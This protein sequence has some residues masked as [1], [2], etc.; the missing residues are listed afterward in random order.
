M[1]TSKYMLAS[2]RD[3]LWGL[4]VS[5]IG[6]E[7]IG[8]NEDY[9]TSGH[10]SGYYF[11]L[12]KGRVLDEYQMLYVV[13]GRGRFSSTH[14]HNVPLAAGDAFL[15]FPGEWHCYHP[16]FSEGWKC[17]WIGF[18]GKN[19]DDRVRSGFLS[20]Q[21]P[22]Y[23]LGYSSEIEHLYKTAFIT[24]KEEKAYSQQMLAGIVNHMIGLMYS[25]ER[26]LDLGNR[27]GHSDM[28]Q[29]ACLLIRENLETDLTIQQLAKELGT[30][31]S[32]FRRLFK[33][34]TSISPSTYQ[35]DL[36]L[37][38]AKELLT[39]TDMSIKE[40]AYRLNFGNP[41]YFSAKFKAKMGIKPTD[42]R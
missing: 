16:L 13:S 34:Y 17:Y 15:L 37:Q 21:H 12:D 38:R 25:L 24:A 33:E 31:Y 26:N 6:Y 5:T 29:K 32:N 42:F 19:M 11:R 7:E 10:A 28:I 3:E 27:Q 23:H 35:Q 9:P 20:P 41:D 36:R 40:I 14:G 30:S 4:T 22:I 1:Q 8:A 18:K 2:E 39:S